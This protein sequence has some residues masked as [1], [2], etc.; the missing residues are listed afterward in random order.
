MPD[1]ELAEELKARLSAE[2]RSGAPLRTPLASQ[3]RYAT[4][5][6]PAVPR[7]SVHGRLLVV[8]VA[9]L[10][11][12][13]VAALAGPPQPRAWLV[14]SVG[15]IA[16]DRGAP[17]P[18]PANQTQSTSSPSDTS[19]DQSPSP[20]TATV[21]RESPEPV[22]SPGSHESPEPTQSPSGGET[23]GGDGDHSSPTPSASPTDGGSGG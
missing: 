14:Q 9:S 20:A 12:L 6:A 22:E 8:V 15:N 23:S 21:P 19:S 13:V 3:A 17:S 11:V 18:S 7:R 2:L 16:G 4:A 5:A 1:R 10:A